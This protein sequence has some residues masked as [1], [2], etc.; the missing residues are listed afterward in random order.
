MCMRARNYSEKVS[1]TII[2]A[3]DRI[4]GRILTTDIEGGVIQEVDETCDSPV[5][6]FGAQWAHNFQALEAK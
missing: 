6:D 3:R 4:G 1:I 5:L 2:E